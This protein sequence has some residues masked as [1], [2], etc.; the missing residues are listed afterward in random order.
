MRSRFCF[1]RYTDVLVRPALS[2]NSAICVQRPARTP[3]EKAR[4]PLLSPVGDPLHGGPQVTG[5]TQCT[6][7]CAETRGRTC[8]N[9]LLFFGFC[10]AMSCL[11]QCLDALSTWLRA[12]H[13]RRGRVWQTCATMAGEV[14]HAFDL[15]EVLD[16]WPS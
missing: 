11:V 2:C 12:E 7:S 4:A 8:G 16:V 1:F 6:G 13:T 5:C 10:Y 9:I 14:I 15:G 3:T